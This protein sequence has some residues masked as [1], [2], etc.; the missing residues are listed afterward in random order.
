MRQWTD[1]MRRKQQR[2]QSHQWALYFDR[3]DW[4][5][6]GLELRRRWWA[7][8]TFDSDPPSVELVRLIRSTIARA[9]APG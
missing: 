6:I 3:R 9:D 8:T 5:R 4:W 1:K 2:Q 7:E